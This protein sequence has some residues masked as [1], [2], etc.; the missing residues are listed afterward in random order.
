MTKN[1][2]DAAALR[3][4]E[5]VEKSNRWLELEDL[6][7][8]LASPG[9]RRFLWR[10]LNECHVFDSIWTASAQIHYFAGQQDVGHFLQREIEAAQPEAMWLMAKENREKEESDRRTVER[11]TSVK[12][13][14]VVYD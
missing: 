4:A 5:K 9:G 3:K 1:A 13:E 14:D 2:S 7:A 6:R 10:L 11:S 8:V 12:K